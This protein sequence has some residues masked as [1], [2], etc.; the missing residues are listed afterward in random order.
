V[1]RVHP[2][3]TNYI[4]MYR[5]T[6]FPTEPFLAGALPVNQEARAETVKSSEDSFFPALDEIGAGCCDRISSSM[7]KM[8]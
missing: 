6:E 1:V 5:S 3:C 8:R 4:A 7:C 2:N